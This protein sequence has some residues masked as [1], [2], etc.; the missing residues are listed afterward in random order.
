M[1]AGF[2]GFLAAT[3]LYPPTPKILK[4]E[5]RSVITSTQTATL[6]FNGIMV[7]TLHKTPPFFKKISFFN[8]P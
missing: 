3:C 5:L 2:L 7:D 4:V 8:Y 6:D 1:S